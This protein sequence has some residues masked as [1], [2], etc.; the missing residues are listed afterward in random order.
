MKKASEKLALLTSMA[1]L[2]ATSAYTNA[3]EDLNELHFSPSTAPRKSTLTP[4]QKKLR[5]KSKN[6]R[7]ARKANRK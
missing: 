5:A 6:A 7:K 2:S 1:M 4:K 3:Y